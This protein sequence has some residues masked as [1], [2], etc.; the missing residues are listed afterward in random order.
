MFERAVTFGETAD[1]NRGRIDLYKRGCFVL[2]A[3]QSRERGGSKEVEMAG[4][5]KDLFGQS[6]LQRGRRASAAAAAN[7][8]TLMLN[9]RRQA[10]DYAKALPQ[11]E[12]WPPFIITCDVGHAFEV[13]ADFSGQGKNY[14]QFPDRKGFRIYLDDLR[15][16]KIRQRLKAIWTD[17][18]TLDPARISARATREIAARLAK[19][20]QDLEKDVAPEMAAMFLMRCLFTM[21]AEDVELL[22]RNSFRDLLARCIAKP[23]SFRH[24]VGQLWEAMSKGGHAIAIMAD[25]KRFNGGFFDST[26]AL[27]LKAEQIGELL[28]AAKAD[29]REVEPAIFGTL[30]EQALSAKERSKLGAH[31]T[32]RAYVERLVVATV[33]EPLRADWEA[34]LGAA[35]QLRADG[36][37][38]EAAKV[39]RDFHE[40]LCR[41]RVLDP[42]CGTGN[43]LYVTLELMK[44]LEG[45]VLEALADLGGEEALAKEQNSIGPNQFLGL[46]INGRARAIAELVLWIGYLQWY[47]RTHTGMPGEPILRKFDNIRQGDAVLEADR[48]ERRED[49]KP[50]T[51]RDADGEAHP[52]YDYEKPRRPEWP[53]AEFIVG[54]PPF[55][56][57]KDVRSR[58]GEDYAEAL[59]TAHPQMN[60]SADFVMYWWDHAAEL[61]NRKGTALRRFGLVT[62]NS[63]TQ[64][65]QRRTI[66]RHL[67]A[68]KPI[69]LVYAISDHPWTKATRDAAAVR[70]AMSVAQAGSCDGVLLD[71]AREAGLDSDQPHLEFTA[72]YGRING[73]LSVGANLSNARGLRAGDGLCSRGVSLHGAGFIVS[74]SEAAHLGL[75]MHEGLE[76]HIRPYRNGRDLMAASRKKMVIDLLGLKADEVRLRF[77]EVYQHVVREVKEKV[78]YDKDGKPRYVGRDWNN[79]ATYKDFWW[80]FGEPRVDLRPALANL[81]RYIAT[82][83]TAKHRVFQF[84]DASI[85]PDNKLIVVAL[86]DPYY[87]GVLSAH[88]H[89]RWYRANA[90]KLGVYKEDA[91]Y[92]KSECFDPFP[93]PD[94]PITLRAEIG[95]LAEELDAH[96]KR[97]QTA[98]PGLT[99][100]QMYNVL[101][102][103][104]TGQ[105]L[106]SDDESICKNGLVLILKELHEQIDAK[107]AEAYGWPADMSDEA[108]IARLVALNAE[109]ARE[110]RRGQVRW[111][112]PEYQIPRFGS[113]T[114][115]A[116]QI[117]ADL[118]MTD[119]KTKRP[120]LPSSELALNQAVIAALAGAGEAVSVDGLAARFRDARK[121]APKIAK[122][123]SAL[124]RLGVLKSPDR[125]RTFTLP[126]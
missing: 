62:T 52:V 59:W 100:T 85:L 8:D 21:F 12:G 65:F 84:L 53:E 74:P 49:G 61:L 82:V 42:A 125:G 47:F 18:L 20:S 15:D 119:S 63:I 6:V 17:P 72:R 97:Q 86:D 13:F 126:R 57:G 37:R 54:N 64:V 60:D 91:V 19:V 5:G 3:K 45:E 14:T 16:E 35:E 105:T 116:E 39:V 112:R 44:R 79:R 96:R 51:W 31:Y 98:H 124:H 56:G 24:Q 50:V 106:N 93:F 26:A 66:E 1:K 104:K 7:W 94:P 29:W 77:P 55:I 23:E 43:F 117:E 27:D 4:A 73:D 107:V 115:K 114:A 2:E 70:I 69:S 113:A 46:E 89:Y 41:T 58:L 75:G 108:I 32:P 92:V 40:Q 87:L 10:E 34:V 123:L 118:P 30:L 103:L 90:G 122:T 99:L 110:E 95:A 80:I 33:I 81:P 38:A 111:L 9:A 88:I 22:P 101:E 78:E 36:K 11:E 109:R 28:Q 102:K 120:S 76:K 71:V 121:A 83:E 48:T 68:K 25:V 67:G